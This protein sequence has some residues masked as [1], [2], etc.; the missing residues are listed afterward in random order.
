MNLPDLLKNS[1]TM[2]DATFNQNVNDFATAARASGK[3]DQDIDKVTNSLAFYRANQALQ[4]PGLDDNSFVNALGTASS[5][6]TSLGADPNSVKQ[7]ASQIYQNRIN[8]PNQNSGLLQKAAQGVGNVFAQWGLTTGGAGAALAGEGLDNFGSF[9]S[10]WFPNAGRAISNVGQGIENKVQG[11]MEEGVNTPV[12]N[13]VPWGSSAATLE[14]AGVIDHQEAIARGAIEALGGTSQIAATLYPMGIMGNAAAFGGASFLQGIGKGESAGQS[15][16]EGAINAAGAVFLGGVTMGAFSLGG[17]LLNK[18]IRSDVGKTLIGAAAS[19]MEKGKNLVSNLGGNT[20]D[21]AQTE[22]QAV[23]DNLSTAKAGIAASLSGNMERPVNPGWWDQFQSDI[24]GGSTEAYKVKSDA[25]N[26]VYNNRVVLSGDDLSGIQDTL[27]N[28]NEGI[29]IKNGNDMVTQFQDA[30]ARIQSEQDLLKS[31][32]AGRAHPVASMSPEELDMEV[33]GQL[34]ITP[35]QMSTIKDEVDMGANDTEGSR[36]GYVSWTRKLNAM[37]NRPGGVNTRVLQSYLN[38]PSFGGRY[39]A[40]AT[41]IANAVR[42][43]L[44]DKF[45]ASGLTDAY[46]AAITAQKQVPE[47]VATAFRD[48]AFDASN[49][50]QF[51]RQIVDGETKPN[52]PAL[53]GLMSMVSNPKDIQ[54]A[55]INEVKRQVDEAVGASSAQNDPEAGYQAGKAIIN[56]FVNTYS[57]TPLLANGDATDMRIWG[58]FLGRDLSSDFTTPIGAEGEGEAMALGKQAQVTEGVNQALKEGRP[59]VAAKEYDKMPESDKG[60]FWGAFKTPEAKTQMGNTLL[61]QKLGPTVDELVGASNGNK[62][63]MDAALTSAAKT[64]KDIKADTALWENGLTDKQKST[65]DNTIDMIDAMGKMSATKY[66]K[67]ATELIKGPVL[68]LIGHPMAGVGSMTMGL[69]KMIDS[70]F[71][72]MSEITPEEQ[73]IYDRIMGAAGKDS[74][75]Y[76]TYQGIKNII[77]NPSLKKAAVGAASKAGGASGVGIVNSL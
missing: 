40:A 17:G 42:S 58:N 32:A 56:R 67:A 49:E 12:G 51:V 44:E 7:N 5:A 18:L 45:D 25:F 50:D 14:K 23:T 1:A 4:K 8:Q 54:G 74:G 65:I 13:A 11:A 15:A 10:R 53:K 33:A 73:A 48:K 55:V 20:S 64:Y 6:A 29:G 34:G 35:E 38:P 62:D 75:I 52:E 36:G 77:E 60:T 69:G 28:E 16:E 43:D 66:K 68:S 70:I 24:H 31:S 30:R 3:N 26:E 76:K 46:H 59:E 37:V 57:G 41:R 19:Y 63:D 27:A 39:D 9:L 2:D 47:V 71:T 22:L 61:E 21:I 72:N